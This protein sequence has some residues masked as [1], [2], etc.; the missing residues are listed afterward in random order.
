MTWVKYTS[1]RESRG[2][3]AGYIIQ[4]STN[5][6]DQPWKKYWSY[7]SCYIEVWNCHSLYAHTVFSGHIIFYP[8]LFLFSI[9]L[10]YYFLALFLGRDMTDTVEATVNVNSEAFG[11]LLLWVWIDIN[12]RFS[13]LQKRP[14][15]FWL[16]YVVCDALS[17]FTRSWSS[18]F[19]KRFSI[20]AASNTNDCDNDW[21][22]KI[23]T[24]TPCRDRPIR[25]L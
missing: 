18:G 2:K 3:K 1:L 14:F 25:K 20:F 17:A 19:V 24:L 11:L 21:N 9:L 7:L 5:I 15:S 10:L 12:L 6:W 4:M 23:E 16:K 8:R 13:I 22:P